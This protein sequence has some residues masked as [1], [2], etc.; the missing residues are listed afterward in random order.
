MQ[1]HRGLHHDRRAAADDDAKAALAVA[2]L[3]AEAEIVHAEQCMIFV[4]ASLERDLE[5]ARQR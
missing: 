3:R 5:F 1:R 2:D 4:G